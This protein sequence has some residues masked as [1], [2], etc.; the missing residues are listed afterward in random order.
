[1]RELMNARK[2]DLLVVAAVTTFA[3][4]TARADGGSSTPTKD[5]CIAANG[6]AQS[7]RRAGKFAQARAQLATCVDPHCPKLVSADCASR[8]DELDRAQPTVLFDVKDAAGHDLAS[9]HVDIDGQPLT[10]A[11][12]GTA[13]PVDPGQ[14]TF[15]FQA[16]GQPPATEMLVIQEQ[17]KGRREH[18]TLGTP[19]VASSTTAPTTES[20]PPPLQTHSARRTIGLVVGGVGVAGV[21]AGAVFGLLASSAKNDYEAHCGSS[22]HQA[23]AVCDPTGISGHQDASTKAALSTAFF[24]GGGVLAAGGAVLFFTA[25]KAA[26]TTVGVGPGSVTVAGRF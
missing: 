24:I 10:A 2:L 19:A 14:H 25:P 8:L 23:A 21:A 1:V 26:A 5:Q 17:E 12:D 15:H 4:A 11:L 16:E 20:A 22:I 18:V 6:Q 7:L 9:V 13:I 3:A